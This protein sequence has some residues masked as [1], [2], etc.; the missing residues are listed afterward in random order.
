MSFSLPDLP[1][2]T[3]SE[4]G[5]WAF[6]VATMVFFAVAGYL[7][8][9]AVDDIRTTKD[10]VIEMHSAQPLRDREFLALT[11]VVRDHEVRLRTVEQ[12]TSTPR[13]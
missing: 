8:K 5:M 12:V 3:T 10:T 1:K 13:R 6:R 11:D 4:W 7:G 2:A 9:T